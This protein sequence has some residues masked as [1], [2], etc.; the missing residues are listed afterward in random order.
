MILMLFASY[1]FRP[2]LIPILKGEDIVGTVI[3]ILA[4]VDTRR[5]KLIT[6]L[7]AVIIAVR[8]RIKLPLFGGGRPMTKIIPA[9][10]AGIIFIPITLI[11][12]SRRVQLLRCLSVIAQQLRRETTRTDVATAAAAANIEHCQDA[13]K[14]TRSRDHQSHW[15]TTVLLLDCH[16][17]SSFVT[18][19][20][21]RSRRW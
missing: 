15:N 2:N 7:T 20:Q 12:S 1:L 14:D 13:E 17:V 16:P 4:V 3:I 18:E 11:L 8:V 5:G 6:Q 10:F 9:V 21:R 19:R